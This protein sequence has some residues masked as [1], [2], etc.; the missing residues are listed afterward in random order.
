MRVHIAAIFFCFKYAL[1][2]QIG[3]CSGREGKSRVGEKV[4]SACMSL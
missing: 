3:K 4:V 1:A 2:Y